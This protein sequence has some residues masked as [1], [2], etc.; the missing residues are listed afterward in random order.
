[1]KKLLVLLL[2]GLLLV[3]CSTGSKDKETEQIILGGTSL[4]HADFLRQLKDPLVE[5]GY[6]LVVKE[7][8]DYVLPN[9]ALENGDLDANYFQHIPYLEDFNAS[10]GTDLVPLLKVHYEPIA[11]YGGLKDSL[12]AVEAGDKVIV[13]DD[14]TNL[15]RALKLLE[16]FGWITLEGD[17]DTA[18]IKQVSENKVG[19][20]IE[21]ASAENVAK[22]LDN[23]EYAVVNANFA[24]IADITDRGIQAETISDDVI[25]N[26]VNVVAVRRGEE[27]SDKSKAILKAFEDE[28]VKD[29][30]KNE[31]APAAISVLGE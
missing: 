29:Y 27:D 1:M 6:E 24:L 10:H 28:K 20:E 4:P 9:T 5:Q 21:L 12:D 26:I 18:D 16:S 25:A 15:P 19:I 7:F 2:T 23:A 8:D 3:G 14:A 17:K 22:L 13:P 11:L 30:I 31:Y